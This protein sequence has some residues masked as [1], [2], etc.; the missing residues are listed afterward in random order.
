MSK[1]YYQILGVSRESSKDDIKKAYRTLSKKYHPDLNPD[2]PEAEEKFKEVSEAYEVLSDESQIMIVLVVPMETHL[3]VS[4]EM[5]SIWKT[6]SEIFS[7]HFP[8]EVVEEDNKKKVL[9]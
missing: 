6:Y 7:V 3:V 4:V 5:D 9:I 1:N 8:I 2:N